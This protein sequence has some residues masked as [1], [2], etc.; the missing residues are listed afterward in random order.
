[1]ELQG[2]ERM[3]DEVFAYDD[4][5]EDFA[6]GHIP[7]EKKQY[8]IA[9]GLAAGRAAAVQYEGC[10][11]AALLAAD[12][13]VIR[14][15]TAPSR[16]GLHAQIC[17]TGDKKQIDLFVATAKEL[18]EVMAATPY[19]VPQ[20]QIEQL[21]LAHEFYHWFEYSTGVATDETV[22]PARFRLFG[23]FERKMAVR[24]TGEIAAFAFAKQWC[25]L[26]VHPKAMD[27][28]LLCQ[29][30]GKTPAQAAA[31]FCRLQQE[32]DAACPTAQQTEK[33]EHR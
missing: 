29:K 8:Y 28:L 10:D 6:Y 2:L 32:Y 7:P 11:L 30:Q 21:F 18:S 31:Q 25:K 19:P 14:K 16:I 12:G 22:E 13:V 15:V 26:P 23:L 24:R 1:M 9:Q 20:P 27:Y 17:Y 33:G 3:A 5:K 4:L